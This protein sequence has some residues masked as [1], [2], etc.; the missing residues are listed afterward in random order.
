MDKTTP[1]GLLCKHR[2]S[3]RVPTGE[4]FTTMTSTKLILRSFVLGSVAGSIAY[5]TITVS[6]V[7]LLVL[8]ALLVLVATF[9]GVAK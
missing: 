2:H 1:L 5:A 9:K 4:G 3:N 7:P 8:A 6:V